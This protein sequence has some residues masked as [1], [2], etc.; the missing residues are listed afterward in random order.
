MFD[1][2]LKIRDVNQLSTVICNCALRMYAP[3]PVAQYFMAAS[4]ALSERERGRLCNTS[5]LTLRII[6]GKAIT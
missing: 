1:F 2:G 3:I 6:K 4:E 5:R